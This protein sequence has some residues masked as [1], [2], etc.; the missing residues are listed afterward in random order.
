MGQVQPYAHT[1]R[2][3]HQ[4]APISR[5]LNLGTLGLSILPG[6]VLYYLLD[7]LG[8]DLCHV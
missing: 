7:A 5:P 3:I 1:R 4:T 6:A 8:S 2:N